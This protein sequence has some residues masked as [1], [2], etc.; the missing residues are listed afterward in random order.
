[1]FSIILRFFLSILLSLVIL[2]SPPQYRGSDL[3]GQDLD[4]QLANAFPTSTLFVEKPISGG[5][6]EA[7][8]R[9]AQELSQRNMIVG[10]G[11]VFRYL[12]G[13]ET[14]RV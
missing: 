7:C 11:Y 14:S 5:P 2:G 13:K 9:V 3:E 1:M 10:V 4:L 12:K 6:V 8:W